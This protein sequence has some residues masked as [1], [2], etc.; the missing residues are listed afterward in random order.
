MSKDI[1]NNPSFFVYPDPPE[2]L[3]KTPHV[4]SHH[5]E[6]GQL[7]LGNTGSFLPTSVNLAEQIDQID[8]QLSIIPLQ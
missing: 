4:P 1:Q 3:D 5:L 2:V 6:A 8:P 7:E